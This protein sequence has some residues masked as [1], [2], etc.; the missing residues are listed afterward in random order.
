MMRDKTLLWL[1]ISYVILQLGTLFFGVALFLF[2]YLLL[3][4]SA[5]VYAGIKT[6]KAIMQK[7]KQNPLLPTLFLFLVA[8]LLLFLIYLPTLIY[9]PDINWK[10]KGEA[11][12]DPMILQ[13]YVPPS[14]FCIALVVLS[15]TAFVTKLISGYK[16]RVR[17]TE[18]FQN[19]S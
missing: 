13:A 14:F 4:V 3:Y 19:G 1:L 9:N 12:Q 10:L 5:I 15:L 11:E 17:T 18:A 7:S 2:V 8:N 6:S 16:T